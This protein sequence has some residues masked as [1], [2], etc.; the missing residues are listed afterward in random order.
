MRQ[1][2]CLSI[3]SAHLKV[4]IHAPHRFIT[5]CVV[6]QAKKK[7]KPQRQSMASSATTRALFDLRLVLSRSQSKCIL[8]RTSELLVVSV[9]NLAFKP[10][11]HLIPLAVDQV[12]MVNESMSC[13]GSTSLL[14]GSTC[15]LP[16]DSFSSWFETSRTQPPATKL[17]F[18]VLPWTRLLNTDGLRLIDHP[19]LCSCFGE[20]ML[21]SNAA[22]LPFL[23]VVFA[24]LIH[25]G[26]VGASAESSGC[27]CSLGA[28][29]QENTP[30]VCVLSFAG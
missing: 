17:R 6:L 4:I 21:H 12:M 23:C 22:H 11:S 1:V 29:C 20:R 14:D 5:D 2:P 15:A 25:G 3:P 10:F 13:C 30:G 24:D 7:K 27:S 8:K 18:F 28:R 26:L 16:V 9:S 19:S